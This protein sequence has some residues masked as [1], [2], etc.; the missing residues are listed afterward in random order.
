MEMGVGFW[1]ARHEPAQLHSA[2]IQ[3][4]LF[5]KEEHPRKEP[6][7]LQV[8]G[9]VCNGPAFRSKNREVGKQLL[10]CQWNPLL[11]VEVHQIFVFSI[12]RYAQLLQSIRPS[13]FGNQ[14]QVPNTAQEHIPGYTTSGPS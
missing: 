6:L 8:L 13:H 9:H 11:D 14:A 1:K 4:T 7:H 10:I 12:P 3:C 2:S 5:H